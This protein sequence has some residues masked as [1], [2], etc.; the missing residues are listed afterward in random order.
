[1][2]DTHPGDAQAVI[3]AAVLA[4]TPTELQP[5]TTY[6]FPVPN[7]GD[8]RVIDRDIDA[9]RDR[10]RRKKG[11]V[12]VHDAES[13]IAYLSKH[14][15]PETEVYADVAN[16]KLVAVINAH[17]AAGTGTAT[18]GDGIAH[19][20]AGWGDHRV[21]IALKRTPAWCAW[22]LNNLLLLGQI[23]FAEHVENRLPDFVAPTGADMLELAQS[24]H[25][26]RSVKFESSRRLQSSETQ[27]EYRED[28]EAKAGKRGDI[29]IPNTFELGLRPYEGADA[30]KVTA[31][32]RYRIDDGALRVGYILDRPEDVLRAAF[33]DILNLVEEN[34]EIVFRGTPSQ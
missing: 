17:T 16:A 15:V 25:A 5:L 23:D 1:V 2:N 10:P 26:T 3:D 12:T 20:H 21:T 11:T 27:L 31:R 22:E 29:A 34:S 8:I 24:F 7:G 13:F 6:A 4:V 19:G 28:V 9:Y 18:P 32:F 14:G 30:Y 33:A